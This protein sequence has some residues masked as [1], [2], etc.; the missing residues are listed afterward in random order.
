MKRRSEKLS[1][2]KTLEESRNN[3]FKVLKNADVDFKT[4]RK[5]T[6]QK[7]NE[8]ENCDSVHLD[9]SDADHVIRKE[10]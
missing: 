1:N 9:I 3:I 4:S 5:K 8:A 2:T 10:K 7:T 6:E